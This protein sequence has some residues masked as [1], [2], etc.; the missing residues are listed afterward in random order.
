MRVLT[1]FVLVIAA[2]ALADVAC[3]TGEMCTGCQCCQDGTLCPG[4]SGC[5]A[6]TCPHQRLR[7]EKEEGEKEG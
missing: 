7:R 6:N 2:V 3:P 1:V 4:A 5:A